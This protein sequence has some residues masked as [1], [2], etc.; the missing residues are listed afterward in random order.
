MAPALG[1]DDRRTLYLVVNQTT[2][3]GLMNGDSVGRIDEI[4]ARLERE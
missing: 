1:G 2:H 4:A 3:E